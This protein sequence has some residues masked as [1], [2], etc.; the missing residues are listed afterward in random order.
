MND[1][2]WVYAA[3]RRDELDRCLAEIEA[4]PNIYNTSAGAD[5]HE[6]FEWARKNIMHALGLRL[7]Y[8]VSPDETIKEIRSRKIAEILGDDDE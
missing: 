7:Q 5:C 1:V 3:I 2:A 4:I 6:A 8:A